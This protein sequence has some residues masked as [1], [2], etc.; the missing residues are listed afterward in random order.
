MYP[1]TTPEQVGAVSYEA[2]TLTDG[3][4]NQARGNIGAAPDGFGLGDD[5]T[6]I[7]A[8][9]DLNSITKN[10]WYQFSEPPIHAPTNNQDGWD[11]GYSALF[12]SSRNSA[13]V[14]QIIFCS[15]TLDVYGC[16]IKRIF[17]SGKW[18][19]WEWVNPPMNLGTEYRTTERYRG[20]PVYVNLVDCGTIP[21]QGTYKE[22]AFPSDVDVI[23]S[24]TAY[25]SMRG[26]TLPY[27]DTNG[28][29]YSLAGRINSV[30]IWNYSESL[31]DTNVLA[32]T[33]YTKTTN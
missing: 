14:T 5:A 21:A 2:Q 11:G 10:G 18:Y 1:K 17:A 3:Q 7:S 19:P 12:V 30:I 25:S 33:K 15:N 4:K 6:L 9:T 22:F 28:V 20:K 31:L 24:V 32:L 26:N 29:R 13:I 8:D 27:Y 16:Q 23:I